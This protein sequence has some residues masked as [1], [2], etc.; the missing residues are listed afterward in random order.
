MALHGGLTHTNI[1]HQ[2]V[3]SDEEQN[4]LYDDEHNTA[5]SKDSW[6]VEAI[7]VADD[8]ENKQKTLEISNVVSLLY[9]TVIHCQF[10]NSMLAF[11]KPRKMLRKICIGINSY[12][13]KTSTFSIYKSFCNFLYV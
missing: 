13:S 11:I 10:F 6:W 8:I 12:K 7:K 4:L 5:S 1:E 3:D 9:L 2:L